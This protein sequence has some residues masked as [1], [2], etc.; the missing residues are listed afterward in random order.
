MLK[1]AGDYILRYL[2]NYFIRITLIILIQLVVNFSLYSQSLL[3][4]GSFEDENS[5]TEFNQKCSPAGWI[6]TFSG[7]PLYFNSYALDGVALEGTHF[8]QLIEGNSKIEGARTFITTR[9]LCSLRKNNKYQIEFYFRSSFSNLDSLGILFSDHD[10]LYEKRS[11]KVID[12]TTWITGINSEKQPANIQWRKYSLTYVAHGDETFFTIGVFKRNDFEFVPNLNKE[13]ELYLYLDKI[14]VIPVNINESI[15]I[16]ADSM[17]ELIYLQH[18]RHSRLQKKRIAFTNNPPPILQPK[19]TILRVVDSLMVPDILFKSASSN[20]EKQA[21][22]VLDSFLRFIKNKIVDSIVCIGHTDSL[23]SYTYNKKLSEE[24][25]NK[26]ANYFANKIGLL[27]SKIFIYSY[28][29]L[30]PIDYNSTVAGRQK[31]RRVEILFY[32]HED[33]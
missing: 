31:N 33:E 3:A 30:R 18:E 4:N 12:P 21:Y 29:F 27:S 5:C 15:C 2:M 26:V 19:T 17:K 28:A 6:T 9:L 13:Q 1:N 10:F 7:L 8:I 24:R 25:A 16:G 14:S 11:F 20:L 22:E 23:G 32:S